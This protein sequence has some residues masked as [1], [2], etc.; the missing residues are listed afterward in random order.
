MAI[1]LEEHKI[2]LYI[3]YDI[4]NFLYNALTV[5]ANWLHPCDQRYCKI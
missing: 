2:N 4:L 5:N 1:L 3:A